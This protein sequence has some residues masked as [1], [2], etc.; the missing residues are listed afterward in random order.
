VATPRQASVLDV[1]EP[2]QVSYVQR[3]RA[4]WQKVERY[5]C[6]AEVCIENRPRAEQALI[7]VSGWAIEFQLLPDGRRQIFGFLLP[8][9]TIETRATASVGSRAVMSITRLEVVSRD[10]HAAADG[11]GEAAM[12]RMLEGEALRREERFY[13][14]LTRIGRLSAKERIL[15]L[16]LELHRRLERVG[17]VDGDTFKLPVT[18]EIF[19][20]TLGLSVV[21]IN[22]TLKQLRKEGALAIHLGRVTLLDRKRLSARACYV[23]VDEELSFAKAA[24]QRPGSG[25]MRLASGAVAGWAER[26]VGG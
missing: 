11:L 18:Q 17:L 23:D 3:A 25:G 2:G 19:A 16:L 21:H 1:L 14:Q 15:H 6:G 13:D 26:R 4:F 10:A 12:V 8:G 5:D 20:D 9:D 24:P 22:R 7:I